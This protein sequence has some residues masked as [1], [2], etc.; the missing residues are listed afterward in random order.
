MEDDV[1]GLADN[2]IY[3]S[4]VPEDVRKA[5]DDAKAKLLEG[6]VKVDT[7]FGMDESKLKEIIGNAQ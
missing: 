5:V 2:S 6:E 7:A 1:V 4:V 3:Q